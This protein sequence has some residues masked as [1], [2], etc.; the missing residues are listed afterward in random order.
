MP[1]DQ[2]LETEVQPEVVPPP[3]PDP[4]VIERARLQGWI[5]KEDFKGDEGRWI[6]ADEFVKRADHMMPILKSVNKKLEGKLT[7]AEKRL[8]EIQGT[9]E[10][11]VKVQSKVAEDFYT[12]KVSELK[13]EK[14]K[15]VEAGDVETYQQLEERESKIAKPEPILI[16]KQEVQPDAPTVHPEVSRW[17]GENSKWFGT[18]EEL[19]SYAMFVGEQLKNKNDPLAL[20][21]NEYKFCEKVKNQ[22]QRTFPQK[23]QNPN[24]QRTDMDESATRG[25]EQQADSE[26]KGW[27]NLPPEAK[28]QCAKLM[29]DI[30][31][32]TKEKYLNDYFEEA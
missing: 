4:Q 12:A 1:E 7:E 29:Q 16:E 26:K 3:S 5:P 22:V 11:M 10:K 27:N 28:S 21:G 24:Q 25:S 19:T 15:A 8:Q 14:R 2:V 23:F 32:Y 17:I 13:A 31:G 18:D 6:P 9:M 20:P 30:P